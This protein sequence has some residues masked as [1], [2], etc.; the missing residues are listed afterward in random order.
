MISLSLPSP[1]PNL[2][3]WAIKAYLDQKATITSPR[4]PSK[5]AVISSKGPLI[6]EGWAGP[7][8]ARS[9]S[10]LLEEGRATEEMLFDSSGFAEG[11]WAF[12][13]AA[14]VASL[15]SLFSSPISTPG[16]LTLIAFSQSILSPQTNRSAPP[17]TLTPAPVFAPQ[18]NS[19]WTS[20]SP[21]PNNQ[22]RSASS[23]FCT[24]LSFSR[25]SYRSP[26]FPLPPS[27]D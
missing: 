15:L 3:I 14:R 25:R 19:S 9:L 13:K 12:E 7:Y 5:T 2:R 20:T 23:L 24:N 17:P 21:R 10:K 8:S 18:P 1:P 26:F 27:R 16:A 4:D 6:E 11:G 22:R